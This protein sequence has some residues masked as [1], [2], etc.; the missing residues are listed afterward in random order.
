MGKEYNV[1]SEGGA[2][3]KVEVGVHG[4]SGSLDEMEACVMKLVWG[5]LCAGHEG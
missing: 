5:V 4:T 1:S 2:C 3:D